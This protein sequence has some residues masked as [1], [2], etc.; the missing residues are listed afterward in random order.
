MSFVAEFLVSQSPSNPGIIDFINSSTGS[1]ILIT[2]RRIYIQDA[3]GNYLVPSGTTTTY[4]I[5]PLADDTISV[6]VLTTDTA[7]A[8]RVD[9]LNVSGTAL[10]TSGNTYCFDVYSKLFAYALVQ[11]LVPPITLDTAYSANL[12]KLWSCILGA[13]NAITL[14]SDI[15]ASQNCLNQAIYLRTN[16]TLFF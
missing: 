3:L 9:Y 6:N 5:W 1:D 10:Y 11:G 2:E 4:I 14:A 15:S 7:C 8:I 16:Q 12:A 13:E